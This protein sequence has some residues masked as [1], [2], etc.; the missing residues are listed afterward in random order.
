MLVLVDSSI[1]NK[2]ES[3]AT[4]RGAERTKVRAFAAVLVVIILAATAPH[5]V[6]SGPAASTVSLNPLKVIVVEDIDWISNPEGYVDSSVWAFN[7][8]IS[9]LKLWSIQFDVLRLDNNL[10]N[11][12][13]FIDGNGKPKYG[14]IIWNCRQDRFDPTHPLY[15]GKGTRD[16]SVLETAVATYG[17][18]LIA[19]ANTVLEP[20]IRGLLGINYIDL[21][22][23]ICWYT[24]NDSF[25]ITTDHFITRGYN[26]T[27]IPQ[28]T[29]G[30]QGSRVKFDASKT[31]VLGYQGQ[32]P[33]LAVRDINESTKAVWIGGNRD[34]VFSSSA[35][36]AK[37]FQRA[38]VYCMGYCL[39][40]T[41]PDTVFLRMDDAGSAESAYD[42]SWHYAQLSQNQ[43]RGSLIQPLLNHNATLG[44][45]YVTGYPRNIEQAVLKSWTVDWVDPYGTRQ[46]LT[47]NYLGILEGMSK[48]VLEVESHGWTHMS[49][50]LSSPPG[51]WWNNQTER[52]NVDWYREFYDT[53]RSKE[54][55]TTTQ[56]LLFHNSINYTTEAFGT[57]PL[58][59]VASNYAISGVPSE[60]NVPQ[61]Y[62]YK[63]AALEG[64]G[65]A[66]TEDGYCYLGPQGDIVISGMSITRSYALTDV[67]S[68]RNRLSS[69]WDI[70]IMAFFHDRDI[71]SNPYFLDTYLTSM[72]VP[73]TPNEHAV[74]R[75]LS[76]D[77]FVGY[78]HAKP[79]ASSSSITFSFQYDDHYCKYFGN[80]DSTWTLH[81]SDDLLAK[82]TSLGKIDIMIDGA[83][84]ATVNASEYFKEIQVLTVPKG[85]GTHTIQFIATT[86]PDVAVVNVIPSAWTIAVGT[87]VNISVFTENDGGVAETFNVTTYWNNSAIGIQTIT[88]LAP[89]ANATS[90]FV[91]NT[92]GVSL[93]KYIIKAEASTVPGETDTKNN[94]YVA[95]TVEVVKSPTAAFTYL[96]THPGLNDPI[97]F[98]ASSSSPGDTPIIKYEW[99]FGDGNIT[100]V[101][102][103]TITHVYTLLGAY[104]VTLVVVD[105]DGLNASVSHNITITVPR[106]TTLSI[107]TSASSK[108]V[109]FKVDVNGTLVDRE[110]NG[111]FNATIIISYSFQG[112]SQWLPLTSATTDSQGNYHLSWIPPIT[113]YFTI[114]AYWP[115]N[116]AYLSTKSNTTVNIISYEGSYVFSVASNSTVT[117]LSFNSTNLELGFTASGPSGTSGFSKTT[118]AKTLVENITNVKVYL[119]GI[120]KDYSLSST[121]DSWIIYI[122]Y[123]HST[124]YIVLALGPTAGNIFGPQQI[125]TLLLSVALILMLAILASTAIKKK[126]HLGARSALPLCDDITIQSPSLF[127]KFKVTQFV[128]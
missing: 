121:D 85:D 2:G 120:Q 60:N 86:H 24:M 56:G 11:I 68:I 1:K 58:T 80:H 28:E 9:L 36:M 102:G 49:P 18:S 40:E 65:L 13:Q 107:F 116:G 93:G 128:F 25:V 44:V 88:G 111:I 51:P 73:S 104:D 46:N 6:T 38:I 84:N 15:A 22:N 45:M 55:D 66:L 91:W 8:V 72:E 117:G 34:A 82:L 33:Q 10:L 30:G 39:Y 41:Y 23:F 71:A 53:R 63:I 14:V 95:G 101:T 122:T 74:K 59:F 83:Y 43:V 27:S 20:R 19:L 57:F 64:F 124:H 103:P 98:D 16:W 62:T 94:V 114:E 75:Y 126:E 89:A 47:S 90:V 7:D 48:G 21:S 54:I 67:S 109:G 119:D 125:I 52:S 97:V 110:Q 79:S 92:T 42:I 3:G 76:Q 17:I 50:D 78:L 70:P 32:W 77:E 61:N 105:S 100:A 35:I 115:G 118:I 99:V 31:T 37:I 4:I 127:I 81:V 113:G 5:T 96:P 108:S 112:I 106:Q 123:T 87:A 26:G 12:T 69:G 29:M